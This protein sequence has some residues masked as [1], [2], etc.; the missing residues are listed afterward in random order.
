[1]KRHVV[2]AQMYTVREFCQDRAGVRASMEK[3]AKIGYTAIQVSGFGDVSAKEIGAIAADNGL[4]IVSSHMDWERFMTDLDGIIEDHQ[5][6]DCSHPAIGGIFRGYEG[7]DGV[8]RFLDDLAP[9]ALKL[10][11]AGMDFSYHNHSHEFAK[12]GGV[13]WFQMM[14]DG[15]TAE[16]LKLEIDTYWVQHGGADPAYWIRYCGKR[17]PL[18]HLK[19]MVITPQ[20][21]QRFGEIGEGNL[22]WASIFEAAEE[23]GVEWFLV[24]QDRSYERDPFESLAI[25]Y[26][27]LKEMGLS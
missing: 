26:R 12:Y 27:N 25:S 17:Q 9:V 7:A 8:K 23:V 14:V 4:K 10:A 19:D 22:N 6:W 5:V 20:R 15:S 1:M 16:Q 11:S 24:E 2:G 21:E 3:V 18:L 13:T